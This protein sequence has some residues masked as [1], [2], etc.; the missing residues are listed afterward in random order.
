MNS[1]GQKERGEREFD[2][3]VGTWKRKS[4]SSKKNEQSPS[5]STHPADSKQNRRATSNDRPHKAEAVEEIQRGGNLWGD[6][7]LGKVVI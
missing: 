6:W 2:F 7:K 3:E 1:S 4:I 5:R